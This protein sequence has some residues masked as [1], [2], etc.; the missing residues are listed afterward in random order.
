MGPSLL[1]FV[2]NTFLTHQRGC[3]LCFLPKKKNVIKTIITGK[4]NSP[5]SKYI[6]LKTLLHIFLRK[7]F[8]PLKV[9]IL[10]M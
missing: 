9:A 2:G 1:K 6:F 8:L 5:G 3:S 7:L 4:G 10:H